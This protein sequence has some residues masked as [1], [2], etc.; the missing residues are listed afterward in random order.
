MKCPFKCKT[1]SFKEASDQSLFC[2]NCDANDEHA[3]YYQLQLQMKLCEVDYGD[4]VV[5]RPNELVILRIYIDKNFVT[6]AIA[7]ATTFYKTG[8]LPELLGKW[9]SKVS[10]VNPNPETVSTTSKEALTTAPSSTSTIKN[11]SEKWCYCQTEEYGTMIGCDNENCSIAW[12]HID[13]LNIENIP[14]GKWY[15]PDCRINISV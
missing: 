9:Y 11:S 12:Y 15:C 13:C 2:L 7:N 6:S 5:W 3:Y 8:I 14:N 1:K 4:L 10:M